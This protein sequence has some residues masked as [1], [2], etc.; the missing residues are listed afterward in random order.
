M[1]GHDRPGFWS[2]AQVT[3]RYCKHP[4]SECAR[5]EALEGSGRAVLIVVPPKR[6]D[7]PLRVAHGREPMHGQAFLS[8]PT[9]EGLDSRVVLSASTS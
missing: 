7:L 5:A 3:P 1:K 4:L 9:R 2:T 6:V 8:E